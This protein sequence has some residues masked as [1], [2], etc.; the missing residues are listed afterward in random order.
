VRAYAEY[1]LE[2]AE[3]ALE[4]ARVLLS[5]GKFRGTINRAYYAM[6]YAA[7]ALLATKG[8]GSSKHAGVISFLHKDFVKTG[9]FPAD[10]ASFID[11][12]FRL[13][14]ESDYGDE[15]TPTQDDAESTV[16]RA[17]QFVRTAREVL[18]TL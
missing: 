1:R 13:R 8:L 5:L 7:S 4:E 2:R 6:F 10:T 9:V 12:A 17:E 18:E 11:K 15:Y 3:E 14:T 16:G